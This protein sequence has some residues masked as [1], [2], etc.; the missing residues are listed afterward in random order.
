MSSRSREESGFTLIELMVVMM[1]IG[2]LAAVA[3]P[4]MLGQKRR[5][6]ETAAKSDVSTIARELTGYYVDGRSSLVL[7]PGPQPAT[8]QLRDTVQVVAEGALSSGNAL[9]TRG[10]VTS[11]TT[12]CVAVVPA[13]PGAR[14]W[15]ATQDGL[16]LGDC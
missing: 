9:S 13:H 10:A 11:D 1:I 5:A 3:I 8:W 4:V 15:R 14:P 16:A 7:A 6:H 12:Y 2:I